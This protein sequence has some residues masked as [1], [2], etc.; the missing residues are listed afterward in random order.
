M[1]CSACQEETALR[2]TQLEPGG[3]DYRAT[4]IETQLY[5]NAKCLFVIP[6]H[7]FMPIPECNGMVVDFELYLPDQM[8][9]ADAEAFLAMVSCLD[10]ACDVAI[11][12]GHFANNVA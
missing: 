10:H 8:A 12:S 7:D 3:F 9:V 11:I 1:L 6:R 5:S 2:L 4:N